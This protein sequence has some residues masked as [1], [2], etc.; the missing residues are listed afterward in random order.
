VPSTSPQERNGNAYT[1]GVAATLKARHV[2][3]SS[4]RGWTSNYPALRCR[5]LDTIVWLGTSR[6]RRTQTA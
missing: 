5:S 6:L 4:L 1:Q 3:C 2:N